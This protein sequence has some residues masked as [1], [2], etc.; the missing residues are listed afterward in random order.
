MRYV[1]AGRTHRSEYRLPARAKSPP[2]L[3]SMEL[4]CSFDLECGAAGD[5]G[6]INTLAGELPFSEP[7]RTASAGGPGPETLL[8]GAMASSYGIALSNVLRAADLPRTR[9]SVR[10]DAVIANHSGKA[11]MTRVTV[12]PTIFGADIPRREAYKSAA[13]AAR[14]ECLVGRSVRGNVAFI[15]GAVSLPN[16]PE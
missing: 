10:A 6:T 7:G 11:R 2:G 9:I 3:S 12:L 8:I 5:L 4:S 13:T 16:V 14:D 15:V 1:M